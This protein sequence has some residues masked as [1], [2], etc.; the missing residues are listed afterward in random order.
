MHVLNVSEQES[1]GLSV[2]SAQYVWDDYKLLKANK[3]LM[4]NFEEQTEELCK[5]IG[6]EIEEEYPL[7]QTQ[8]KLEFIVKKPTERSFNLVWKKAWMNHLKSNLKRTDTI[9]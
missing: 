3:E 1:F 8:L 9:D 6:K 4:N 7:T 5:R 2:L